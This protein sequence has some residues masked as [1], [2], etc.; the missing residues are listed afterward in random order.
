MTDQPQPPQGATYPGFGITAEGLQKLHQALGMYLHQSL[1][2][3][4]EAKKQQQQQ[5]QQIATLVEQI[6]ALA[7]APPAPEQAPPVPLR[8]PKVQGG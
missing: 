4:I 8:T 2:Q 7:P 1:E 5:Q 3:D 6:E